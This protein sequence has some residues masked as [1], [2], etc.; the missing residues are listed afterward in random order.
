MRI[1]RT[2]IGDID[3]IRT[4]ERSAGE[5]FRGTH[6]ELAMDHPPLE[7]RHHRAAIG[8]GTHWS[9]EIDGQIAGFCCAYPEGDLLYID[10]LSV[11]LD[12]QRRGVGRALMQHAL[13]YARA[14]LA[15][16]ALITD[17]MIPWNMPFYETLGFVEWPDPTGEIR[18][19]LEHEAEEGFDPATRVAMILRFD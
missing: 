13:K 7:A 19:D 11:A 4:V 9:A 3:E 2:R 15:G 16:V 14:N 12:F 8:H 18:T 5:L 10:E 1:R 17:R 6:L